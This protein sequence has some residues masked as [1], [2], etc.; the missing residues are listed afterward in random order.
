MKKNPRDS[1][2]LLL[3]VICAVSVG[4]S[5]SSGLSAALVIFQHFWLK[6]KILTEELWYSPE[7]EF[8]VSRLACLHVPWYNYQDRACILLWV[9][10]R[11]CAFSGL[12]ECNYFSMC[13]CCAFLSLCVLDLL[14]KSRLLGIIKSAEAECTV[15]Y[16][17]TEWIM[18]F[19][20][21]E[22]KKITCTHRRENT[23]T[24][25]QVLGLKHTLFHVNT[26]KHKHFE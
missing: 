4:F 24:E 15:H 10:E 26:C 20:E 21:W 9:F 16:T 5:W 2:S 19:S 18:L 13:C 22:K 6:W 11:K 14:C 7:T 3:D 12:R 8:L 17:R 1:G 25:A 23:Y